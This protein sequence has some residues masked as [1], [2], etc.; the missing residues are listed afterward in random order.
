[1]FT[2]SKLSAVAV[3]SLLPLVAPPVHAAVIE[4]SSGLFDATI[5]FFDPIG[6]TFLAED[7][8]LGSIALAFS[9]NT[10][11]QS[12]GLVTMTLYDGSG[13]GGTVLGSSVLNLTG[14]LPGGIDP[15]QFVDVDFT[16]TSLTI[17]QAYTIAVTAND[18]SISVVFNGNDAYASGLM[19][20]SSNS[21]LLSSCNPGCDLNF[22]VTPAAVPI[23]AAAWLLGSGL[24]GLV[25]I[26]R[27]RSA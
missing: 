4:Q 14:T 22:R 18:P 26:A 1:M 27:R 8:L 11:T 23:P 2:K 19:L 25:G 20:V 12:D 6:Q 3:L 17:G 10:N 24:L 21:N 16:G 5:S 15:P 7:P 13:F 9:R